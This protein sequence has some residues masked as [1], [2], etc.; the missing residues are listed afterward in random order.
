MREPLLSRRDVSAYLGVPRKTL[1]A[2]ASRGEGPPY[3]RIGKHARYRRD[4]LEAWLD[5]RWEHRHTD[6]PS[7]Q[8]RVRRER[9]S[10]PRPTPAK[11]GRL[12][13]VE[14]HLEPFEG[15]PQLRRPAYR[16]ADR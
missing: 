6:L 1:D 7:A 4:E 8:P 9:R 12:E 2:W 16:E 3:L 10:T 5:G 11:R 13:R 14:G 15:V